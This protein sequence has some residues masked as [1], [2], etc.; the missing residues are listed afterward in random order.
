MPRT[1]R[2]PKPEEEQYPIDKHKYKPKPGMIEKQY[3][4]MMAERVYEGYLAVHKMASDNQKLY[5][6]EKQ[7][8]RQNI[9]EFLELL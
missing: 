3:K 9:A 2:P 1:G 8:I 4:E 6:Y 7:A 5:N